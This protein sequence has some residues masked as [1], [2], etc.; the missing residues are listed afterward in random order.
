MAFRKP[1]ERTELEQKAFD[2]WG[3]N[4][5]E[6]VKDWF[7]VTPDDWQGD[8]LNGLLGKDSK[9][10]RVGMK[11]AHGPGKSAV[12]SWAGWIFMN[13]Y[14]GS[15]VVATAPTF[16]QLNDVLWPEFAKWYGKMP[17]KM[18][19]EWNISGGHIR[20]NRDP[21][22]WFAVARTSNRAANLQGF[23][24]SN[25]LILGDEASGIP[26]EV[27]E[28]IEGTLSEAGE[29]GKVAKLAVAGN[30]NFTAGEL[31][32]IFHRNA[33]LYHR[34][35]VTGDTEL[36]KKLHLKQGGN[37]KDHGHVYYSSRVKKKY[38][39]TMAK[40]YGL[41]SAI[42]DVRVRGLFPRNDDRAVIPLEFAQRAAGQ[43]LPH[44]DPI[45]D[46][47]VLIVDPA[48]EG[49]NEFV[50]GWFRKGIPVKLVGKNKLK[51]S[52][53]ADFVET[54]RNLIHSQGLRLSH[55]VV[56]EPGIGGGIIDE[57]RRRDF[58]VIPYNGGR[59]LVQGVDPDDEIRQFANA[60]ARDWWHTRRLLEQ[61]LLPLP[62]DETL[63]N[64]LACLHYTYNE[65]EKIVVE[66]KQKLKDRLGKEASPDRGD[67]IVMG[68]AP[69]RGGSAVPH[70]LK[71]D[72]I[73]VGQ[74]RP[75][76]DL[77]L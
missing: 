49:G 1:P 12:M 43:P 65:K 54:E 74:D 56:D 36:L 62:D 9:F 13:A 20:H 37:H 26:P 2:N 5:V 76:M 7:N 61:G 60:R 44:F 33:E 48:R 30:P 11:A 24:N 32:D 18:Q 67:V 72:D 66:S 71:P 59:P 69:N 6:A 64:Q 75:Q 19:A 52:A 27:F 31:Y 50:I 41:D 46:P 51:T 4:P 38:C 57:L 15:R 70:D 10:D 16:S 28:V 77:D 8:F 40:K 17:D 47:V 58:A 3:Q 63:I 35:T 25:I 53:G 22:N 73:I 34:I 42:Y 23:H 29:D 55:V 21:Y 14:P 39:D 68:T 45:A